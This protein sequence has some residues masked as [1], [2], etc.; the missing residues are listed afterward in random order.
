MVFRAYLCLGGLGGG[1]FGFF[2]LGNSFASF[3]HGWLLGDLKGAV[4]FCG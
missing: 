4:W 3:S 1:R 2:L